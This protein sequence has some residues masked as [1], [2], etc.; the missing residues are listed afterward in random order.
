[1]VVL[2]ASIISK[3]GK[4]LVSRQFVDMSRI[5]IE[6]LLAAFPKLV[7]TGKQHTYVE[8]E[9]VRY[10]YQPI[11]LLYL[12]LVTN[13]QSNILEDLD[14][15]RLL[16]KLVPEY[17]PSLDEEGVCK[18]A[19]ELIFAFDE[20]ISL[21]HKENVTVAQV[22]QY[23]EMESHEERLHKLLM[24]SK[25]N[26]TKDVM[27]RKASEIDKSKIEKNRG[28]K[29]GFMA[30]SGP[31][32]IESSF[33]DM[34]ISSNS[35]GFGSGS[36]FGLS[37][38]V[39][40]FSSKSKGRPPSTATAPSKGLGMQLGKTQ[41]TSQLMNSLKAEGEVILEDV[42]PVALQSRSSL[43]LTDP[44]TLTIEERLNVVV[45]RDGLVSNF[46]VQGTLS[47][48]ILNQEDGLVQFQI[49]NQEMPGL[50][51]KTHPNINKEL[52]NNNHIVGLKDPNRPFPTG[53]NDVNLIKWRIQGMDEASL[54]LTVNCWPTVS[55][56]ETFV[57]IEYEAF[58][59]F[60]LHNVLISIPLP[61]SREP[62]SVRQIDGEWRYD[63][64]NSTLEWSILL[65]DNT[66]RSGSM[67]FVV[68]PADPSSFFPIAI[69]SMEFV[70][71]PAD[72]SSFFPIAIKFTAAN[73]FSDVKVGNVI[74]IRGG[75]PP[76][77][78]QRIQLIADNYEVV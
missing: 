7:G 43:P 77:Y 48:Q 29:G 28:D 73:T 62:P 15:L 53:Q 32:R 41:K 57:N 67:E 23:C 68:P 44:I 45:R 71:P 2:A 14:T 36:G 58:E 56:S 4:A 5:R 55:G 69:R 22:K 20:A 12:L 31:R 21:G 42:P 37:S 59:T 51:F 70:V 64:R 34:S 75:P 66:N 63:A 17:A 19:F 18:M 8:T 6:G 40:S 65:V 10:V 24:Q 25:I 3:T 76:K 30:M 33:S 52:F 26:E 16:S 50:S 74:P 35:G 72:P 9:N 38:D 46:D 11:E 39:E 60:D 61:A 27:K 13:K 78:A 49:E 54:P 1:M 47:V